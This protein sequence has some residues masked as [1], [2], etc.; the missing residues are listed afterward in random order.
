MLTIAQSSK[1]YFNVIKKE[2]IQK[3]RTVRR[4]RGRKERSTLGFCM[5]IG[6]CIS[7]PQF[8]AL[9]F[10]TRLLTVRQQLNNR[11]CSF[12]PNFP[13]ALLPEICARDTKNE[14][15]FLLNLSSANTKHCICELREHGNTAFIVGIVQGDVLYSARK[16]LR[17][18][19]RQTEYCFKVSN[20]GVSSFLN[21]FLNV[22]ES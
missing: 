3:K 18:Y 13:R 22:R 12:L 8:V 14:K 9:F 6:Y 19:F 7:G 5:H 15:T 17:D 20:S 2:H 21:L 16:I 4:G 11:C 1:I 10:L